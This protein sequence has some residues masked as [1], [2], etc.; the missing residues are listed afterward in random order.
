MADN[1]I[2]HADID[3][4]LAGTLGGP[5]SLL[6]TLRIYRGSKDDYFETKDESRHPTVR[7]IF[8]LS[9]RPSRAWW[10][11]RGITGDAPT[12]WSLD[13]VKPHQRSMK[14]QSPDGCGK[15]PHDAFGTADQGGGKACKTRAQDFI[16]EVRKDV[17]IVEGN[18]LLDAERDLV[19]PA[20]LSYSTGN[21]E[22]TDGWNN[23]LRSCRERGQRPHG[24]LAEWG[25][26]RAV[27]KSDV[28]FFACEP[29]VIA[30]LQPPEG[31]PTLWRRIV[32]SVTNLKSGG[33][34]GVMVALAGKRDDP[35]V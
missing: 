6:D 34:E 32:D 28:K 19:G 1:I 9:L 29:K 26:R 18:V 35:T 25:F 24:V 15:C 3:A 8:L 30:I 13:G 16:I 7:G 27:S 12:C 31:N 17:E 21:R 11:T 5:S 4:A 10:E 33:A 14:A 20:L 2:P 23:F 22:S